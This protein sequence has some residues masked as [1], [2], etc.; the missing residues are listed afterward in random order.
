MKLLN[1]VL[2]RE[3][4]H[5]SQHHFQA[6][7]RYVED[8][9]ATALSHLAASAFGVTQLVLDSDAVRNGVAVIR[10]A[11]GVMPDGLPFQ[12]PDSDRLPEPRVFGDAFSPTQS[13]HTLNLVVRRFN[14]D[15]PNVG[16]AAPI[17]RYRAESRTIHDGVTGADAVNVEVA[18]R[19]FRVV[20]DVERGPDDVALSIAR[21]MRDGAG[22]FR[23]DREFIP[24]CTKLSGSE[25]LLEL[26]QDVTAKLEAKNDALVAE[27]RDASGDLANF[28]AHEIAGFWMLHTI[29]SHVAGL[30]HNLVAREAHPERVY[31][32]FARLAG[33]LST[34]TIGGTTP[35]QIPLY[36]HREPTDCFNALARLVMSGLETVVPQNAQR[37]EFVS[38][39]PNLFGCPVSDERLYRGAAWVLGIRVG[40]GNLAQA[41]RVP[42]LVKVCSRPH[43]PEV[44]KRGLAAL[45]LT[46]LPAPP[47]AIS[48]RPGTAYFDI[49]RSGDCW[50]AV[51]K[52][53]EV[54]VFVPDALPNVTLDLHVVRTE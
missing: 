6:Q 34:F 44:I 39:G 37:F 13:Q 29:R 33:E 36:D 32:D 45:T 18:A 15:A 21:V 46:P 16:T 48:P 42:Q 8:T 25:R 30:R 31:L 41:G 1:A 12:M 23:F 11:R 40:H 51:S 3:G 28:A 52:T 22:R 35:L 19:E 49:E 47:G 17:P 14:P 54:G 27:R 50:K 26:V 38:D 4:M 20:L 2:W 9:I 10:S 24:T 7:S 43:L 53:R 5:L